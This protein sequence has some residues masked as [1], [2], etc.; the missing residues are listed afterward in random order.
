LQRQLLSIPE[1]QRILFQLPLKVLLTQIL[2]LALQISL[3][4]FFP[5][6]LNLTLQVGLPLNRP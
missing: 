1:F 3:H 2:H 4:A 6:T 5:E